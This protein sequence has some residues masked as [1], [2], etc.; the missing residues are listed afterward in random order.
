MNDFSLPTVASFTAVEGGA[1][2][3]RAVG[4]A[5]TRA[6]NTALELH[7]QFEIGADEVGLWVDFLLPGEAWRPDFDGA[8]VGPWL[9]RLRNLVVQV[10]VPVRPFDRA[11][12]EPYVRD[13]IASARELFHPG[14]R[15]KRQAGSTAVADAI[16]A[17][18]LDRP[19]A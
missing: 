6:N 12:A 2:V 8:R 1:D 16:L 4:D 5:V 15:R 13:M 18:M 3:A 10:A 19:G 7:D 17:A 9:G 14:L 11:Q